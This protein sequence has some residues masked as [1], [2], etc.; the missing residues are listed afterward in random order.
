MTNGCLFCG[1]EVV[2]LLLV[3]GLRASQEVDF[4]Q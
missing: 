1:V 3:H 4:H 2:L